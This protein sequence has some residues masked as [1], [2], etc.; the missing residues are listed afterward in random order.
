M[1]GGGVNIFLLHC[2]TSKALG[3]LYAGPGLSASMGADDNRCD[4]A[5]GG[6][7]DA[8]LS[9]LRAHPTS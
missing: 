1:Q 7:G 4:L 6:E 8:R 5:R 2:F 9:N 3:K